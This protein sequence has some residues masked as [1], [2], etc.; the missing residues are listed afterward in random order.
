MENNYTDELFSAI[1]QTNKSATIDNFI[2]TDINYPKNPYSQEI[3]EAIFLHNNGHKKG[4]NETRWLSENEIQAN[5]LKLE[6]GEENNFIQSD[7]YQNNQY[8]ENIKFYNVEQLDKASFD[9]LPLEVKPMPSWR[10]NPQIEEFIESQGVKI[11]HNSTSTP[12]YNPKNHTIYMPHRSQYPS[13]EKYYNDMF[14]EIGHSTIIELG[15]EPKS[16]EQKANF[17]KRD[18][19]VAEIS[20]IK[21]NEMTKN[22]LDKGNSLAYLKN[23]LSKFGD[24]KSVQKEELKKA[25]TESD[26]VLKLTKDKYIEATKGKDIKAT[27]FESV[28]NND[29]VK[30]RQRAI[31]KLEGKQS[32]PIPKSLHKGMNKGIKK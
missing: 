3:Y 22:K 28:S 13:S 27:K 26:K 7:L 23:F 24:D 18:E 32:L 4:F 14:H 15:R 17:A 11:L 8:H 31:Q 25:L 6:L 29:F 20:A 5:G 2:K 1:Q 30:A 9:K 12:R 19:L 16:A 10:A 21:L